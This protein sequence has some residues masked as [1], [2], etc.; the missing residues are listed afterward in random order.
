M[1][2]VKSELQYIRLTRLLG[3]AA[4]AGLFTAEELRA[5]KRLIFQKY[6]PKTV[7]ES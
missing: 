7:W 1:I 6:R 2:D 5:A 4:E 3:Q